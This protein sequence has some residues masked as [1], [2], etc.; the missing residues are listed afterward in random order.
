MGIEIVVESC[1]N[2]HYQNQTG[3]AGKHILKNQKPNDFIGFF[4]F[5]S[6][7]LNNLGEYR[8][9]IHKIALYRFSQSICNK[10]TILF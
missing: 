9:K 7:A 6:L 8:Q 3:N 1:N 5:N 4:L 2:S 10:K